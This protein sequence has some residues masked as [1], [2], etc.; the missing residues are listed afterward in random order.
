MSSG[1]GARIPARCRQNID[2]GVDVRSDGEGEKR[3]HR[4]EETR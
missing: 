1:I 4:E 2:G 3:R